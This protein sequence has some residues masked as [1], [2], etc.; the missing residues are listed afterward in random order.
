MEKWRKE[1]LTDRIINACINVHKELGP[2]FLESIYHN[3]LK[4]E[5]A[6]QNIIFESEKEVKIFYQGIEVGIHR[7]DLF[8]G[9]EIV[10]EIKTVEEISG[11]YYNQ[12]RSYLR[13]VDKEIG[14]LVNFADSRIDVRRV[15]QEKV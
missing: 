10:V 6:R 15:E 8:V 2:G 13:A 4:V 7:L 14:L 11:K 9:D 12:V 1:E 5:F 3:A